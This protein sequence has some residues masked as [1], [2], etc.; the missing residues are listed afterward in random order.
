[1]VE[2]GVKEKEGEKAREIERERD[3]V[4]EG[5]RARERE[6]KIQR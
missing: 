5:E 1:M 6:R 2:G 3:G 4:K